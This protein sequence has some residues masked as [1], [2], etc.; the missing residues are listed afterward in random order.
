[1]RVVPLAFHAGLDIANLT[2]GIMMTAVEDRK[3]VGNLEIDH[4]FILNGMVTGNISV[5]NGGVLTLNGMCCQN[6]I[7]EKG[8]KVYLYGT[9]TGNVLN[10]GGELRVHGTVGGNLHTESGDTFIAPSAV[11]RNDRG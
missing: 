11:V 7:V 2:G 6:L 5:V 4:K 8:A 10:R 1:M 3:I 9:V